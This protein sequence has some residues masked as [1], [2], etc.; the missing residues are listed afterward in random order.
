MREKKRR[1]S[2]KLEYRVLKKSSKKSGIEWDSV[3][4]KTGIL[5][6]SEMCFGEIIELNGIFFY[7]IHN[8]LQYDAG[9]SENGVYPQNSSVHRESGDLLDPISDKAQT[10]GIVWGQI[11]RLDLII[12]N[13]GFNMI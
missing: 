10:W 1:C 11:Q 3:W 13:W 8:Q 2:E 12:R 9:V 4:I 6:A 7:R 5:W